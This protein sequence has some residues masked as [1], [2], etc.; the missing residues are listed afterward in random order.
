MF[1][2]YVLRSQ[3]DSG[4]YIGLSTNL[5]VRLRPRKRLRPTRLWR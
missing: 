2:V 4:F 3:N 1:Y 5:R